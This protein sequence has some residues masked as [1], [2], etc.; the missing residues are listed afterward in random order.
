MLAIITC[1]FLSA[2]DVTFYFPIKVKPIEGDIEI[3]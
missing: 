1:P 3:Q 2:I